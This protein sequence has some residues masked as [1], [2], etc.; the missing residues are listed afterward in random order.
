MFIVFGV[1]GKVVHDFDDNNA[2]KLMLTRYGFIW[3]KITFFD[4]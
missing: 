4:I 3:E 1:D 2:K